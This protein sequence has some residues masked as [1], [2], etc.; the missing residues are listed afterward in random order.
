MQNLLLY[1][2]YYSKNT[3]LFTKIHNCLAELLFQSHSFTLNLMV[4]YF[5]AWTILD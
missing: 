2:L 4:L 1:N 3:N 5:I